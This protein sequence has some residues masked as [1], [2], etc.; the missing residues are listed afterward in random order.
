MAGSDN[1]PRVVLAVDGTD[2]AGWEEV[3]INRSLERVAGNFELALTDRWVNQPER[4]PIKPNMAC[5]VA[6]DGETVI[7]G[8]I[9][10][11]EQSYDAETH[12]MMVRGRDRTGDLF[13]CAAFHR[14][15]EINGLRLDSIAQRLCAPFNIPV[16]A[17]V[18][19]GKAF[20][21]FSIQP[22]ETAWEAIERGCRQRAI[23]PMPDGSGGLLLTRA[24]EGGL[25]AGALR[26]GENVLGCQLT[27]TGKEL[28]SE[29]IVLGQQGSSSSLD[30]L[31]PGAVDRPGAR[32]VR[33]GQVRRACWA[34]PLASSRPCLAC[35][36]GR[37]RRRRQSRP[38]RTRASAPTRAPMG[39]PASATAR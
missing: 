1:S 23:L 39:P 27:R 37:S 29:Y 25:A 9:D 17:Q 24:G 36:A 16:R 3:V 33:R 10:D 11:V 8:W 21:R 31:R 13:D 6:I 5:T 34:A 32:P 18:D 12:R 14:P 20:G 7:T 22:G 4:R 15:F 30:I 2:W 38:P 26:V 19:V 35:W 28:F